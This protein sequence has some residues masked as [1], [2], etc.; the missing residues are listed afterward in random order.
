M[1]GGIRSGGRIDRSDE[2]RISE[3]V[4]AHAHMFAAD[5]TV[6]HGSARFL[7][8]GAC[9]P[10]R[11]RAVNDGHVGNEELDIAG[12]LSDEVADREG[13]ADVHD[14]DT[15]DFL[16]GGR[17]VHSDSLVMLRDELEDGSAYLPEP[18]DDDSLGSAY[19]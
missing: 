1:P 5:R 15:L 10:H 11:H 16:G 2:L 18:S 7:S 4:L 3:E 17:D 9:R 14:I 6:H 19:A 12:S 13:V 8:H